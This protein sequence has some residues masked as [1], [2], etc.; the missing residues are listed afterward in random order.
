[1]EYV[2]TKNDI[3]SGLRK[4][5]LKKGDIVLVHSS[6]SSLGK[7]EG[8]PET[9]I[10]A[11][12]EVV[13]RTG[14][15]MMPYPLGNATIAKVFSSMKG[16]IK[17]I[18]PTHSVSALGAKAEYLTR[19][20]DKMPTA[21]GKGTPF[22]KL[23][24]LGGYILLIGVDQDRNTTLHTAEDYADLPYLS[25]KEFK[26]V[27]ANGIE[28]TIVLKRFPGPHRNFIG[29][30]RI[31]LAKK[32]MKIERIGNAMVR[33]I[34]AKKMIKVCLDELKNNP[35]AFL[36]ENPNCADCVMQR[37]KIKE[38]RLKKECF[39]PSATSSRVASEPEEMLKILQGQGIKTIELDAI[40][41]KPITKLVPSEIEYLKELFAKNGFSVAGISCKENCELE[42]CLDIAGFFGGKYVVLPPFAFLQ[43]IQKQKQ[44]FLE[45]L[46]SMI[47]IAKKK[48]IVLLIENRPDTVCARSSDCLEILGKVNSPYLKLAF[49]P[50]NFAI[51]G[52]KP[53]GKVP[54]K[55]RRRAFVVYI[56]DALFSGKP[57][58]PGY[59]N[60]EIKELISILRCWCFPGYFCL[61]PETAAGKEIFNCEA[62]AFWHLLETM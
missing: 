22:G 46:F 18:H 45:S 37:G 12:V 15:I 56:N 41:D 33:L 2:V 4:L 10:Q 61:K 17:S 23:V 62:N 31:F 34:D 44:Q 8:G 16:V 13:G 51:A 59:G 20:H 42:K 52:E 28:K 9:V 60:A 38:A 49:N 11:L 24:D 21:C 29:M 36:C 25:E 1:M 26:Y 57:Q 55:L 54:P 43:D 32:I 27:D 53:F 7:V 14:T 3:V 39:T 5:G 6:L 47:E 58:I 35:A 50:A 19:D 30:D 40:W 48:N